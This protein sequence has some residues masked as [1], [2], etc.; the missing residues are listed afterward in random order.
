MEVDA[1]NGYATSL[2]TD[3]R[4]MA[5]GFKGS[6]ILPRISTWKTQNLFLPLFLDSGQKFRDRRAATANDQEAKL[7]I[8]DVF[9]RHLEYNI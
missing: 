6:S 3:V 7:E 2:E 8:P 9:G 4:P 1:P 5:E